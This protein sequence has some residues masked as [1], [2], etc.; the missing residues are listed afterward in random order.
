[1][2][3]AKR[4]LLSFFLLAGTFSA[5]AQNAG[6]MGKHFIVGYRPHVMPYRGW[7]REPFADYDRIGTHRDPGI[8]LWHEGE[9]SFIVGR[10]TMLGVFAHHATRSTNY[11]F[12]I[13][14]YGDG[15]YHRYKTSGVYSSAITSAGLG[16][17]LYNKFGPSP[18]AP[19]GTYIRLKAYAT[20]FYFSDPVG[21]LFAY[22]ETK[23]KPN[24]EESGLGCGIGLTYGCSR[25][26][27][28]RILFDYGVDVNFPLTDFVHM[29]TGGY[30][31]S[32]DFREEEIAESE[33]QQFFSFR[34]GVGG[35]LF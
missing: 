18:L 19:V 5:F 15:T 21:A 12:S 29:A 23:I 3:M 22:D 7:V 28:N 25:V 11:D 34:F 26:V 6:Y 20:H 10:R 33:W 31:G 8:A 35:L 17:T 27:R 14:E 32:G 4:F 1:M 2:K 24:Y 30:R 16:V 13:D 9:A